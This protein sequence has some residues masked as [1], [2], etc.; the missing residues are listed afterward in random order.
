MTN[1]EIKNGLMQLGFNSGWAVSEQEIILWEHTEPK[2]SI[3]V[4]LDAAKLWD[5]AQVTIENKKA[6]DKA[7]LLNRLGITADE[8][9]LLLS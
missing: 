4:I 2:P 8:A 3:K 5:A 1:I 6:I 9:A 7:E